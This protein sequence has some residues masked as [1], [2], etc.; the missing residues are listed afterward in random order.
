MKL[1]SA[2]LTP[3]VG[4]GVRAGVA[5]P[6]PHTGRRGVLKTVKVAESRRRG[7][8]Q[9][10]RSAN[11]ARIWHERRISAT[12]HLIFRRIHAAASSRKSALAARKKLSFL[13]RAVVAGFGQAG[14]VEFDRIAAFVAAGGKETTNNAGQ[15][16]NATAHGLLPVSG[17]NADFGVGA[18]DNGPFVPHE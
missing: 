9:A 12:R 3:S 2:R 4:Q 11:Q 10:S 1:P 17:C 13:A 16:Q 14:H 8:W 7:H 15:S 6:P 5:K 18:D